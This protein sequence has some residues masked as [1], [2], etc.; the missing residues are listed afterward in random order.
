MKLE[1]AGVRLVVPRVNYSKATPMHVYGP[2][3]AAP[4]ACDAAS[5][6]RFASARDAELRRFV[7][8]VGPVPNLLLTS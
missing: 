7:S 6:R 5:T 1:A 8:G 4:A 2:E 3:G